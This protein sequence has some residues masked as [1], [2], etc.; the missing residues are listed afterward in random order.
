MTEDQ[1]P[2]ND[3]GR[4]TA[5]IVTKTA[6]IVTNITV[7]ALLSHE[8]VEEWQKGVLSEA[9]RAMVEMFLTKNSMYTPKPS[10][11]FNIEIISKICRLPFRHFNGFNPSDTSR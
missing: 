6:E 2:K 10:K 11:K 8:N 4:R 9:S 5:E 1:K 3:Q 7:N